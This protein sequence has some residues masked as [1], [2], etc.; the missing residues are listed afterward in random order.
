M[1]L[2]VIKQTIISTFHFGWLDSI[3]TIYISESPDQINYLVWQRAVL[4]KNMN[5]PLNELYC[6][7]E[8]VGKINRFI[9]VL[10]SSI[11]PFLWVLQ[12]GMS[13]WEWSILRV[14]VIYQV[15]SPCENHNESQ[16]KN[17]SS[18]ILKLSLSE[19]TIQYFWSKSFYFW[20]W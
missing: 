7:N 15:L 14:F 12:R 6:N 17:S 19:E 10:F 9:R 2:L 16:R 5:Y 4:L 8:D 11:Y 3:Q 13:Y 20:Y 18:Y 1:I